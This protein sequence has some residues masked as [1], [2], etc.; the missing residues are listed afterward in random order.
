M[1]LAVPRWEHKRKGLG[2]ESLEA[3]ND[4]VKGEPED[5][6][7]GIEP[8]D[9]DEAVR[10]DRT[11]LGCLGSTATGDKFR[12]WRGRGAR[13]RA[14]TQTPTAAGGGGLCHDSDRPSES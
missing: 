1:P 13:R 14:Q 5:S 11:G 8:G 6:P 2:H 4:C 7:H 10:P 9:C 3:I 12:A